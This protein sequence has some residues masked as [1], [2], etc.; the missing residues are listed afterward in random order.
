MLDELR[1]SPARRPSDEY[2]ASVSCAFQ[3]RGICWIEDGIDRG[4]VARCREAALSRLDQCLDRIEALGGGPLPVGTDDGFAEIVQRAP[5]RY[6][7]LHGVGESPFDDPAIRDD[8]RWK[9]LVGAL[10]GE[11]A[12]LIYSGLL[13][14]LGGAGE[15]PWHADGEHLFGPAESRL[16]PHCINLFFPLVDIRKDNGPTEVCPG[17]HRLTAGLPNAY[18]QNPGML[19]QMVEITGEEPAPPITLEVPAGSVILFD[20]RLAH[21][22]LAHQGDRPRPILYLT[23]ARPWFRDIRNFPARRLFD[24]VHDA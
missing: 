17:S 2:L 11:E 9:G 20:Y 24:E 18:V 23:F 13:I 6:D 14:T 10:L 19:D 12:V 22:A 16:P 15:Q 4:L 5:G 1:I 8:A 21:R 7:V 3:E